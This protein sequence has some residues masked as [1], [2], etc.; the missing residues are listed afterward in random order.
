LLLFI[1]ST[2]MR[3]WLLLFIF[4]TRMRER[5]LLLITLSFLH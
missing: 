3:E 2:R 4:S 5:L 1:F